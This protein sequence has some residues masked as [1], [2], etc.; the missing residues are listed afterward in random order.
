MHPLMLAYIRAMDIVSRV[1]GHIASV[2]VLATCLVC[3][4]N[5]TARYAF[6]G[7][8]GWWSDIQ[9]YM[10]AATVFFGAPVLVTLNEHVRVDVIY[11]SRSG[12]TKAIID[13]LG[14]LFFYMP[15]C[16]V[17]VWTSLNFVHNAYVQHEVS[18]NAADLL[19]WPVKAL[20][21]LGFGLLVLQG[22]AEVFKRIGFLLGSYS[23][24][25]RYER[26]LQ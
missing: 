22:M 26:P 24:D 3:A 19:R 21:P 14:F 18:N 16:A 17:M 10:F 11:G 15:L 8:S 6:H 23:M 13:L 20:I 12:K 2:L 5:A 4:G 9:W 25:T 7:G 1:F